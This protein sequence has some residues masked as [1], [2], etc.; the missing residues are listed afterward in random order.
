MMKLLSVWGL[1]LVLAGCYKQPVDTF[2]EGCEPILADRMELGYTA[3][4]LG[5]WDVKYPGPDGMIRE[6]HVEHLVLMR[7][8]TYKW[9]PTPDWARSEGRWGITRA[10][11]LNDALILC[12]EQKAGPMRCHF[13]VLTFS[14]DTLEYWNWHCKVVNLVHADGRKEFAPTAVLFS[15][16]IL[17]ADR[18]KR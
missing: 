18:P 6:D 2:S 8:G 12:L 7:G 3:D 1:L 13:L 11:D 14:R 9:T 16:R 5:S 17:R 10:T 15:E 4:I